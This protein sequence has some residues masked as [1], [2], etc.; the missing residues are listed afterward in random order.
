VHYLVHG[1][2][3]EAVDERLDASSDQHQAYMDAQA[4][5]LVARGPTLSADAT[6]HTGSVHVVQAE[7]LEDARRFAFEEPY[8]LAGVYASVAVTRLLSARGGTMWD[9]PRPHAGSLSS[10]VLV[11]WPAQPLAAATGADREV[12]ARLAESDLLVFGGLLTSD[13]ATRSVGLVA[14]VDADLG[15]AA[16]LV[17]GLGLPGPTTSV[18]ALRW[19]RG[20]RDQT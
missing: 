9:R 16:S 6:T 13:D 4:G 7:T 17:A 15:P 2:D 18:T 11:R 20:G 12:L 1:V 8:W 14:A 3:E 19:R 10:L 5:R